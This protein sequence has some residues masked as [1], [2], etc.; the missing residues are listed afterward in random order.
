MEFQSPPTSLTGEEIELRD[1]YRKRCEYSRDLLMAAD[2]LKW[3]WYEL[4]LSPVPLEI[5]FHVLE[6]DTI[7]ARHEF[8]ARSLALEEMHS[9]EEGYAYRAYGHRHND[10]TQHFAELKLG[11]GNVRYVI[12]WIE[13]DAE[14]AE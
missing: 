7:T 1:E 13:K 9:P 6:E 14:V 8:E 12:V 4:P 2:L 5:K 3:K 10:T 11:H